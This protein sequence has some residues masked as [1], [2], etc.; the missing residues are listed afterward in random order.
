MRIRRINEYFSQTL[1]GDGFNSS[2]GVFKV[3][4]KAFN[5][6]SMSVGR[7][8]D[9]S[10]SIKDSA[11][12][13]GD[14]V[15]GKVKGKDKKISGEVIR[16][17]KSEDSKSYIIKIKTFK[18][19]EIVTLIPGTIEYVEDRGNSANRTLGSTV[20]QGERSQKNLKYNGGNVVW[21]SLENEND[22]IGEPLE[23]EAIEG[24]MNTG[25]RIMFV[26]SLGLR[27]EEGVRILASCSV[28]KDTSTIYFIRGASD[29]ETIKAIESYCFMCFNDELQNLD[30]PTKTLLAVKL[31]DL[32]NEKEAKKKLVQ[33]FPDLCNVSYGE[34]K[35]SKDL[36]TDNI[37]KGFL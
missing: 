17:K 32:K 9:P 34:T 35:D 13:I 33:Y 7:D 16:N 5:D 10:L 21:G 27:K 26:N 12:Q 3:N 4:Y 36:E 24:P 29:N 37:I 28:N 14:L 31:L 23:G 20:T 8:P 22:E 19:N 11:F 30:I 15:K 18:N 25:W 1:S 6:L 2:N